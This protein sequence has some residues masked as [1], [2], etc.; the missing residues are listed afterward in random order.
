MQVFIHKKNNINSTKI[1]TSIS[2]LIRYQTALAAAN[3]IQLTSWEALGAG[4][5]S[6]TK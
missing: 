5:A 3:G 1:K 4:I 2:E 6:T